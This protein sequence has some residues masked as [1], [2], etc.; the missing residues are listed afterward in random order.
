[1]MVLDRVYWHPENEASEWIGVWGT[2]VKV[3]SLTLRT[4]HLIVWNKMIIWIRNNFKDLDRWLNEHIAVHFKVGYVFK[5]I[6][7][8]GT[9]KVWG[10]L[11]INVESK[12]KGDWLSKQILSTMSVFVKQSPLS[13]FC[14]YF[15]CIVSNLS[16]T[17]QLKSCWQ[18]K[19]SKRCISQ[20]T[21]NSYSGLLNDSWLDCD[22]RRNVVWLWILNFAEKKGW[23]FNPFLRIQCGCHFRSAPLANCSCI[24]NFIL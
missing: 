4:H 16:F 9:L 20:I 6:N 1:M 15:A 14:S 13:L 22:E 10:G 23:G 21:Q 8:W 18:W 5:Q 17:S 19:F 24:C 7:V 2:P 12:L 3:K 11:N